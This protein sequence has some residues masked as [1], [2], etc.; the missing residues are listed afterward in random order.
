MILPMINSDSKNRCDVDVD[1]QAL[2][3]RAPSRCSFRGGHG[4]Q[5][6]PQ[7]AVRNGVALL[8]HGDHGVGLLIGGHHADGLV[9][10][11]IKFFPCR[12]IDGHNLVALQGCAELTQGGLRALADLLGRRVFDDQAG[13]Q[14]VG[15]RQ[16][17]FS[18]T[19]D[20]KFAGLG[21]FFLDRKSVV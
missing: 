19:L 21:D 9:L 2:F 10:V 3:K 16:Q 1:A 12:R 15:D 14:A 8:E 17:T 5:G 4:H 6:G 20:R 7:Y 18:K 11:R 13:F